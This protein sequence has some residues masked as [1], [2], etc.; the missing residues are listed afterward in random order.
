MLASGNSYDILVE[1]IGGQYQHSTP[2]TSFT[3]WAQNT[4]LFQHAISFWRIWKL[5]YCFSM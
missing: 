2:L 5:A 4:S 3:R 1:N